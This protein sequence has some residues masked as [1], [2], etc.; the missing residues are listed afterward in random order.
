MFQMV[1]QAEIPTTQEAT[2]HQFV[3][4]LSKCLVKPGLYFI[5]IPN[6]CIYRGSSISTVS[7]STDF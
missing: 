6:G 4:D 7:I 5:S 3:V 1:D 2:Q